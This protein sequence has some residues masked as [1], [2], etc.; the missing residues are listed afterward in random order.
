MA[1]MN[2]Y[3]RTNKAAGK[4]L[5]S[6]FHTSKTYQDFSGSR[7]KQQK[8]HLARSQAQATKAKLHS[9]YAHKHL[10]NVK[11]GQTPDEKYPNLAAAS[12]HSDRANLHMQ[13]ALRHR[14]QSEHLADNDKV[15]DGG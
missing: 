2:S 1:K 4:E 10:D 13:L 9:K 15:R 5:Y 3:Q 6:H 7:T 12:R 8:A 11:E 14:K